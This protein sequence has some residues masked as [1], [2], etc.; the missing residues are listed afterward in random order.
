MKKSGKNDN[1]SL[2]KFKFKNKFKCR[3]LVH[4]Y[5]IPFIVGI[6]CPDKEK[7]CT[8]HETY[9]GLQNRVSRK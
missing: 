7:K 9:H 2:G 1:Q 4:A 5:Y 3:C 8:N 6:T